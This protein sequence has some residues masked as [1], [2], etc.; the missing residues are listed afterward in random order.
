[1]SLRAGA[2][3][4]ALALPLALAAPARAEA[5]AIAKT[6]VVV[7]VDRGATEVDAAKLRGAIGEELEA[8]AVAPD[9]ARASQAHG[10][11][12]VSIDRVAHALIVSYGEGGKP[13]TRAIDLPGDT[14]ATARA[15][16]LLAG[17]LARDEAGELAAALR[18][19]KPASPSEGSGAPDDTVAAPVD[20]EDARLDRLRAA[21]ESNARYGHGPR[22]TIYWTMLG[23]S[24]AASGTAFGISLA[25]HTE[26]AAVV[27]PEAPILLFSSFM[28]VPGDFDELVA[29]YER[30][31]ASESS[32]ELVRE[33]V[34]RAWRRSARREHG[35]RSVGGWAE[36]ILGGALVGFDAWA[37]AT[38]KQSGTS[39]TIVAGFAWEGAAAMGVGLSWIATDGPIESALR[40]YE[41]SSGPLLQPAG[42]SKIVPRLTLGQGG[43]VLGIGGRF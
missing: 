39:Q 1:M 40:A 41:G 23:L 2:L 31:H 9:D 11:I 38:L 26:T 7:A 18:R 27:L 33:D 43:G 3:L 20:G 6:I 34:E 10:T 32:S 16:V 25:G 22:R 8:T 15:A 29:Y 14:A 37:L 28:V 30:E 4:L 17:N 36:L 21:L 12:T 13:I 42:G 5:P 19:A 35:I 24:L